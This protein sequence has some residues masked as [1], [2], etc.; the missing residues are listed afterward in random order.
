MTGDIVEQVEKIE[1]DV[2][3]LLTLI[4]GTQYKTGLLSDFEKMA[5][6][7]ASLKKRNEDIDANRRLRRGMLFVGV[8][9]MPLLAIVLGIVLISDFR[10]ALGLAPLAALVTAAFLQ[11]ALIV[12]GAL[13]FSQ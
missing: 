6:D 7:I 13:G 1:R 3:E 5:N 10:N 2:V 4:R 8:I 11:C 9:A 12:L